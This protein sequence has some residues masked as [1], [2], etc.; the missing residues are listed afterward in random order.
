MLFRSWRQEI[1]CYHQ[2]IISNGIE[3][4]YIYIMLFCGILNYSNIDLS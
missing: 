4:N 3:I 2:I 1:A